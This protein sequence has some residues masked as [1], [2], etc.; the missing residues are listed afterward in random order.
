VK[1]R[2]LFI[3]LAV[4]LA[5]SVGLIG[6]NG[7]E[8]IEGQPQGTLTIARASLAHET[9]LPWTG[10][11]IEKNYMSGTIYEP[12]TLRDRD[13][14]MLPCLATDW[15]LS[16][17]GTQWTVTLR[18]DVTFHDAAGTD[19][20]PMTS[21]DVK[22]T[23][24]RLMG[25]D[26]ISHIRGSLVGSNGI[27]S[28]VTDGD[29]TVIFNMKAP[30]VAFMNTCTGPDMMGVVCKSLFDT[31][32]DEVAASNPVGTGPYVLDS[33]VVGSYILLKTVGNWTGQWRM[34]QL[35]SGGADPEKY[36]QYLK[37]MV[38]PELSA[39]VIGLLAG[40]YDIAEIGS[41]VVDQVEGQ[42]GY[43]VLP[44]IV[45]LLAT[46]IIRFGGLNQLDEYCEPPR[47]DPTNPWADNTTV[48]DTT[49]GVLVRQ[50]MN[51]AVNKTEMLATIYEG[52]GIPAVASMS[53]PEWTSTL[54]PYDCDPAQ[55][56][57]LLDDAGYTRSAPEAVDR[58]SMTLLYDER[59]SAADVA[60][61]VAD[62][63]EAVGIDVTLEQRVWTTLRADWSA[64]DLN[65]GYA[66]TH[67]TPPTSLDPML[68]INMAF[69]PAAVLGDY[70]DDATEVLRD[71]IANELNLAQRTQYVKDLGEYVH[72]AATQVFLVGLYGPIGV[73]TDLAEPRDVF[74]LKEDLELVHRV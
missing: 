42:P 65:T 41:E 15:E 68:A 69:D 60:L 55:A 72:D 11:A 1:N 29:D 67:R 39:R 27:D 51:L 28:I 5:L 40:D 31:Y 47:Y 33:H 2:I 36:F 37:F 38:V 61:A 20:G 23:F 74:D 13:G 54:T 66:W 52:T 16:T 17:N 46:D 49:A 63:W 30:N 10:G 7:E 35:V 6:C 70:S 3:S 48:G 8:P 34:S 43:E 45:A 18:D 58:F 62:Y 21:E 9:F 22:Y 26:S 64:G 24:E 71:A 59:Y 44:D 57:D 56:E 19:W 50:A 14:E 4:V 53:I 32:G 12:L 73:S 25:E